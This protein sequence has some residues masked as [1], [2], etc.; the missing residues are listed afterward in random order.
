M[1]GHGFLSTGG[2]SFVMLS[3]TEEDVRRY[4]EAL[5][6]V[7]GEIALLAE[8]GRLAAEAGGGKAIGAFARLT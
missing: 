7:L 8:E 3:H 5:D 6:S 1:L 4:L 2:A